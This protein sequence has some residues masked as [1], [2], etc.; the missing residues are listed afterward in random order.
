MASTPRR[1]MFQALDTYYQ[2][3]LVTIFRSISITNLGQCSKDLSSIIAWVSMNWDQGCN[4]GQGPRV[5]CCVMP[6]V[7]PW[8][9]ESWGRLVGPWGKGQTLR[10]V[11]IGRAWGSCS[12]PPGSWQYFDKY[13]SFTGVQSVNISLYWRFHVTYPSPSWTTSV[14][15]SH[16]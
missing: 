13:Y 12:L 4:M 9:P 11:F 6:G 16:P 5:P 3:V 8:V 10:A 14:I 1:G 15:S 2:M 7:T